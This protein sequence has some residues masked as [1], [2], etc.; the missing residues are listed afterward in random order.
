MYGIANFYDFVRVGD[1]IGADK[2]YRY[3]ELESAWMDIKSRT[4]I[5]DKLPHIN[6]TTH[7]H[8][9]DYYDKAT[10]EKIA[11]KYAWTIEIFGYYF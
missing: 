9:R 3:E 11:D 8:Y 10:R 1:K 5:L 6:D 2:I 4:G 7:T